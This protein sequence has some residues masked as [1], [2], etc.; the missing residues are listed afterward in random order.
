VVK[1]VPALWAK[2]SYPSL[3]PLAGYIADFLARLTFMQ[4]RTHTVPSCR[5]LGCR[6]APASM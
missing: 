3:K 5:L 4:V 6:L 2:K 1:Q